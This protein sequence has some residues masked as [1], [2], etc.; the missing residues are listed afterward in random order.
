M[1]KTFLLTGVAGFISS[2]TAE[3]LLGRYDSVVGVDN[4]ND[5]DSPQHKRRN[6]EEVRSNCPN[7][8]DFQFIECDF[9]GITAIQI[10]LTIQHHIGQGP[11]G[12]QPNGLGKWSWLSKSMF[13]SVSCSSR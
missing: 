1:S 8:E 6:L 5:Y 11:N 13:L 4:F 12:S 2:H 9:Q 10:L 3:A 7:V